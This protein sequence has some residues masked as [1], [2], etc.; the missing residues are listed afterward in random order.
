[1]SESRLKLNFLS[2]GTLESSDLDASRDFYSQFLG[3][4][5][6]RTSPISLMIRLGGTNTI[7]VVQQPKRDAEMPFLNHNGLDVST[8]AEVDA[9]HAAC[10]EEAERWGL[11]KISEARVQH[12]TYSFYFWDRDGNCW[13]ILTN[14]K[15]GYS[16]LF[17]RGDQ[18]GK[19]FFAKGYE[20]P[21]STGS[22]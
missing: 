7:A 6:I 8:E 9:A 12:G 19:G 5:V 10:V 16:W 14:P 22:E 1:M 21:S 18:E 4:E 15:N 11:T 3:L 2:H 17:E 13:E 20:R